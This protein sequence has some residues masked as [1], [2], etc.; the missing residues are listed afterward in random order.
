MAGAGFRVFIPGET[1]TAD[2]IQNFLMSQSVQVYN[3][4]AARTA[5]LTGLVTEGML[6]YLKDTNLVEVFDG[7]QFVPVSPLTFSATNIT[8]GTL[9]AARLPS[10][11][12]AKLP[13]IPLT[14]G[15]TGGTTATEGR[16]GLEIY[17][18]ESEP[19]S[20]ATG[21]IWIF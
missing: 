11:P 15:G 3:D 20:P 5:V 9:D 4:A 13:V 19:T 21:A 6:T 18:Q 16:E 14:K 12:E 10:I 8:S 7:S 17:V 2:N 1:L